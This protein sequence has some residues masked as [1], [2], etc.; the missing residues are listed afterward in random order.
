M[1]IKFHEDYFIFINTLY[2]FTTK[3][4][5]QLNNM[6]TY[7]LLLELIIILNRLISYSGFSKHLPL[8]VY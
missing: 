7:V 6:K 1:C 4:I 2:A 5:V 3:E 8:L